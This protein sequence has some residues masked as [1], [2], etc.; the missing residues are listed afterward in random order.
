MK[1]KGGGQSHISL[2]L[3][4]KEEPNVNLT[5]S[6]KLLL[7]SPLPRRLLAVIK[8]SFEL[9]VYFLYASCFPYHYH[10]R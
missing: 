6:D 2:R 5:S 4:G 3:R 10:P 8:D 1:R 7:T 9:Y